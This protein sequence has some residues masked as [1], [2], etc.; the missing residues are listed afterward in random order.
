MEFKNEKLEK[1][2]KDLKNKKYSKFR[3]IWNDERIR[4]WD[5]VRR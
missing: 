2:E 5:K 1:F 4:N 3:R